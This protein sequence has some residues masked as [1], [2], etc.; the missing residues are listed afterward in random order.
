MMSLF[1]QDRLLNNL[2]DFQKKKKD[3]CVWVGEYWG[4]SLCSH[5]MENQ[6]DELGFKKQMLYVIYMDVYERCLH[7]FCSK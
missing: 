2:L 4:L 1:V 6:K 3:F 5:K 7:L